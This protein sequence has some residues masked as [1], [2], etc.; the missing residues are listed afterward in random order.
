MSETFPFFAKSPKILPPILRQQLAAIGEESGSVLFFRDPG[1]AMDMIAYR[2]AIETI[3]QKYL[4]SRKPMED[5]LIEIQNFI[6]QA[7][8]NEDCKA[9]H[10]V[11]MESPQFLQE[12]F[13]NGEAFPMTGKPMHMKN[14]TGLTGSAIGG[15]VPMD[16]NTAKPSPTTNK[17][18]FTRH[19]MQP[20][21]KKPALWELARRLLSNHGIYTEQVSLATPCVLSRHA[22]QLKDYP[23]PPEGSIQTVPFTADSA[24]QYKFYHNQQKEFICIDENRNMKIIGIDPEKKILRMVRMDPKEMEGFQ[25]TQCALDG[26]GQWIIGDLDPALILTKEQSRGTVEQHPDHG[27]TTKTERSIVQTCQAKTNGLVQHGAENRFLDTK[28][29]GFPWIMVDPLLKDAM[30]IN[31]EAELKTQLHR[32]ERLGYNTKDITK[33]WKIDHQP[34]APPSEASNVLMFGKAADHNEIKTPCIR[35]RGPSPVKG[36]QR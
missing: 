33:S 19:S 29:P 21:E 27:K 36:H 32:L 20:K 13:E 2:D 10:V 26:S 30:W 4:K 16:S 7:N 28:N 24:A 25:K 23:M 15:L 17:D 31:N 9:H 14:K 5:K 11:I 12:L 6:E 3:R 34:L 1:D 18:A 8:K 22:K 35:G